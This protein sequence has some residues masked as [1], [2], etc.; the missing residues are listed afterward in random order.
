[1]Q[2]RKMYWTD[3]GWPVVSAEPYSGEVEQE[4]PGEALQGRYERINLIC[5]LPQGI[6]T[7]VPMKLKDR[8]D[9]YECCSIQGNWHYKDGRMTITYG[10]YEE[11]AFVSAVWDHER[12]RPTIA[13]CGM[14]KE[15]IPFWA[16]RVG[17]L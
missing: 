11:E 1:M 10:P 14:S 6:Q 16:K 13:L 17:D 7:S 8:N 2:V 9:Y 5:T 4:I 3:E 15:G 12:N